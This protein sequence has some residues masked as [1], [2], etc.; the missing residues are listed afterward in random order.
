VVWPTEAQRWWRGR[1]GWD[2]EVARLESQYPARRVWRLLLVEPHGTD[3][4]RR[5]GYLSGLGP[6]FV[7]GLRLVSAG[8]ADLCGFSLLGFLGL[9]RLVLHTRLAFPL[10]VG[11][12]KTGSLEDKTYSGRYLPFTRSATIGTLNERAVT[13]FLESVI[14]AATRRTAI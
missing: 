3:R 6:R 14:L 9:A 5:S 11:F 8:A 4:P 12:V 7:L 1:H 13:H 10:V 2:P